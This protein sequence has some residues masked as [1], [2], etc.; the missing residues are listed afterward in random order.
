MDSG[1]CL[2]CAPVGARP[3]R[4]L[5][6]RWVLR[7]LVPEAVSPGSGAPLMG[8]GKSEVGGSALVRGRA[9]ATLRGGLVEPGTVG[10][11]PPL[12][13]LPALSAPSSSAAGGLGA[14]SA[15]ALA[16]PAGGH[17]RRGRDSIQCAR[18]VLGNRAACREDL[19]SGPH[20]TCP[21]DVTRR[22]WRERPAAHNL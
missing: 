15:P 21:A 4:Q 6:K 17:W 12:A 3:D 5:S 20:W 1:L 19:A 22:G 11:K 13:R 16:G 2:E 9:R 7:H 8:A 18:P 10:L 14:K